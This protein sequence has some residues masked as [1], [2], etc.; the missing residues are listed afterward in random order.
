MT[1]VEVT[2][3]EQETN[4]P[5]PEDIAAYNFQMLVPKMNNLVNGMSAKGLA[6]VYKTIS[7]FP[8]LDKVPTFKTANETDLFNTT[9]KILYYKNIMIQAAERDKEAVKEVSEE[10]LTNGLN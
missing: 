7:T 2:N 3:V 8:F 5:S 9:A 4:T 1:N 6:R 10:V